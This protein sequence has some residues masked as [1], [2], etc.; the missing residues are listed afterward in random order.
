MNDPIKDGGSG[1]LEERFSTVMKVVGL[2]ILLTAGIVTFL[3]GWMHFH[4][5]L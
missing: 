1:I 5:T 2:V 4:P 3:L